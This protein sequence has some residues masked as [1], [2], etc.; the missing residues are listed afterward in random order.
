MFR[1]ISKYVTVACFLDTLTFNVGMY[2]F[3]KT[4]LMNDLPFE[5]SDLMAEIVSLIKKYNISSNNLPVLHVLS[6]EIS[7][8]DLLRVFRSVD[9]Y[10]QPS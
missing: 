4:Y 9:A 7:S 3:V 6:G 2:L 8:T 1:C 5:G 10:V